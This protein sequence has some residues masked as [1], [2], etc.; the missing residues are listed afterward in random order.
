MSE[1]H[2]ALTR[3]NH[4]DVL[5]LAL[6]TGTGDL[7]LLLYDGELTAS[8]AILAR[9]S[10]W[11]RQLLLEALHDKACRDEVPTIW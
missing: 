5:R 2:V 1:G 10:P 9:F 6:A 4:I 7:R 3:H 11:V 8:C